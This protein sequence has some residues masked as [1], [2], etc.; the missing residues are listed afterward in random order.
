MLKS[1]IQRNHDYKREA[2]GTGNASASQI[3][4][5]KIG[6]VVSQIISPVTTQIDVISMPGYGVDLLSEDGVEDAPQEDVEVAQQEE[7]HGHG[8]RRLRRI[9]ERTEEEPKEAQGSNT[10]QLMWTSFMDG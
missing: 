5:G 10:M 7:E 3:K 1:G 2:A 4:L 8:L 9:W 6:K